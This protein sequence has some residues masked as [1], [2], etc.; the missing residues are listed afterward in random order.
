[1]TDSLSTDAGQKIQ[2]AAEAFMQ[3]RILDPSDIGNPKDVVVDVTKGK[4]YLLHNQTNHHY[5]Q[6][7]GQ[8]WCAINLGFSDDAS[9]GTA[10][11]VVQW[12]FLN[13]K[14][15]PVCYGEPVAIRCKDDYL[16]YGHRDCGI[17]LKWSDGPNFQWRLFGGKPGTR[18]RTRDFLCI[19]NMHG[20]VGEPMVWFE[21]KFPQ[22]GGNVGWPS[23]KTLTEI[24]L[25]WA[26]DTARKVLAEYL[27][28]Q[29]GGR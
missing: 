7:K 13:Q 2:L 16:Y 8:P 19:W 15:T 9:A 10:A 1:M 12:Q 14:G 26:E 4:S 22:L 17:N 27:K 28:S 29:T 20:D 3:W 24:A 11:K 23:S 6:Y 5:L 25:R 21:R 18:V